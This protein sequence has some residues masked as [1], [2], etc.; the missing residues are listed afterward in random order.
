MKKTVLAIVSI[1]LLWLASCPQVTDDQQAGDPNSGRLSII[2]GTDIRAL[3]LLP[4]TDMQ[5]V[6]YDV[7]GSGPEGTSFSK[8]GITGVS[9]QVDTLSLGT[10]TITVDSRNADG[11]II[12]RGE[13]EATIRAGGNTISVTVR[14]LPG[15]GTLK[16]A[17]N[18]PNG[19]LDGAAISGTL[20][21]NGANPVDIN[22][23]IAGNSGVYGPVARSAGYYI[24]E[25]RLTEHG[26]LQYA[27]A[28]ALRIVANQTTQ[29]TITLSADDLVEKEQAAMPTVDV[30]GGSYSAAQTVRLSTATAGAD[31]YYTLDGS[32]PSRTNGTRIDSGA[33]AVI[34]GS[35]TLRAIAIKDGFHDSAMLTQIYTI[36]VNLTADRSGGTYGS[37]QTVRFSSTT[38][39]S[40]IYYTT[41][42]AEPSETSGTQTASGSPITIDRSM[43]IQAIATKDGWTDSSL[44]SQTYTMKVNLS[45][46]KSGGEFTSVQTV[47]LSSTTVG[48]SIYYTTNGAEPSETSGTLIASGLA[49]TIDKNMTL[50]AIA[51]K[52]GWSDS[53]P[54]SQSYTFRTAV[55][56]DKDGGQFTSAQ[57]VSLSSPTAGAVIYYTLDGT[58]PSRTNGTEIASGGTI[59]INKSKTLKAI[60]YREGWQDSPV[61][62]RVYTIAGTVAS[63]LLSEA[64]GIHFAAISLILNSPTADTS[65][66][67]TTDGRDPD[68]GR[69]I[70]TVYAEAIQITTDT[71]IK[72]LAYSNTDISNLSDIVSGTYRITGY[73]ADPVFSLDGGG[74]TAEQN[75]SLSTVPVDAQIFYTTDG[76][77]PSAENGALYAGDISIERSQTVKAVAIKTDWGDSAVVERTYTLTAPEPAFTPTGAVYNEEQSV[78]L[79]TGL[80]DAVIRYTADGSPPGAS[81]LLYTEAIAVSR[82]TT[83]KAITIRDGWS[84]SPVASAAFELKVKTPTF[85]EPP[86]NYPQ[87]IL[88]I[89]FECATPGVSFAYTDDGSDPT[90]DSTSGTGRVLSGEITIKVVASKPGWSNS[91]IAV[92]VYRM[93]D[94]AV[95]PP[96]QGDAGLRP[97]FEWPGMKGAESW[98]IQISTNEAFT[99][100]V[101]DEEDLAEARYQ[102]AQD[103][104][105]GQKYY[106]RVRPTLGGGSL[107]NW[108]PVYSFTPRGNY[109]NIKAFNGHSYEFV[110]DK[111]SWTVAKS[112]AASSTYNGLSGYLVTITSQEENDFIANNLSENSWIGA[113]DA[114]QEGQ[115]IWETGPESG[116][117]LNDRYTNWNSGEPNNSG[118]EDYCGFY[119]SNLWNDLPNSHNLSYII[120]YG[121]TGGTG[122]ENPNLINFRLSL[123]VGDISVIFL[124]I[125][126]RAT[127]VSDLQEGTDYTLSISERP[128]GADASLVSIDND[129]TISIGTASAAE[130]GLYTLTATGLGSYSGT[131]SISFTLTVGEMTGLS[132]ADGS[133]TTDT[134]PSL[135]WDAVPGAV[136]YEVQIDGSEAGLANAQA[137]EVS[138]TSY[139]PTRA[140]VN[141]QTHYWR[142]RAK[143]G[144]GQY[145]IWSA[146]KSLTVNIGTVSGLSPADGS[147]TTDTTPSLSWDAVPGAVGYEVQIAD[148]EAGLANAQAVEVSATS[149]SPTRALVNKQTHYW[150]VRAK[151]GDGQY[152]AW[153]VVQSLV[154]NWGTVSGMSPSSTTD[155]TPTFS[156]NAVPGAAGY[157]VQIAGSEAGLANAQAVEVSATSY[158]PSTDLVNNQAHYWRVRAKDG[159]GQY[160]AWSAIASI[161]IG[162]FVGSSGPAGGIVFYDKGSYSDGWRYL[163]AAKKRSVH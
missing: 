101:V 49:I 82:T 7:S 3:T 142:V 24:M 38:A 39:G 83:I 85:S 132:P 72:A 145:G 66:L 153:S 151:D 154:V 106:W 58:T 62:E 110:S 148:S 23:T 86:G 123:S 118:N 108:Y 111:V 121:G 77:Q 109:D 76:S 2:W 59:T 64:P 33:A 60:A 102:A 67:Y 161:G 155:T 90:S 122:T 16:I 134:T 69:S 103:L 136:G 124:P 129:G 4:P 131:A 51:I 20:Q 137:V 74:Y 94:T 36:R 87:V 91:D 31:I 37:V 21:K 157:E 147:G 57:T 138:A 141:K 53:N 30:P 75:L 119:T 97:H 71:T 46:D 10:W 26:I 13:A 73:V 158:T 65:I 146:V 48:S 35:S 128:A 133:G 22:F 84:H 32:L 68:V 93:D 12:G 28:H 45:I 44:I 55:T 139:T 150:R 100:P 130:S 152:G 5:G 115:W 25:Y 120:E 80:S 47:I 98:R 159:D 104:T 9:V 81:S 61:L 114:Q 1:S 42:G 18:W 52:D 14:P 162:Y 96:D 126:H 56:A 116:T 40:S 95:S 143:D 70:G 105:D 19:A 149:Y 112:R 125:T 63:P 135:S 50:R 160:G 127:V 156:W 78:E 79:S 29:E 17:I 117:A 8:T 11:E 41:N 92:G 27:R 88:P 163:E 113:S 54:I 144:D 107:G 34:D 43:T 15:I 89:S 99:S 140:L 6:S